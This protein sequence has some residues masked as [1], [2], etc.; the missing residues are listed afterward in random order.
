MAELQPRPGSGTEPQLGPLH[1]LLR[2]PAAC[3]T[4]I[5]TQVGETRFML[6]PD[7]CIRLS[8]ARA[9]Q[10]QLHDAVSAGEDARAH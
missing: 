7:P 5:D 4:I 9:Q 1:S 8:G 3:Q 10:D 6:R 2:L